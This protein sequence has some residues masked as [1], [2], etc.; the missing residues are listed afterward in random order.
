MIT[1]VRIVETEQRLL[2]R[3]R[4]SLLEG[5][6]EDE[7]LDLKEELEM[8][9][10]SKQLRHLQTTPMQARCTGNPGTKRAASDAPD[11]LPASKFYIIDGHQSQ[12]P[13][14]TSFVSRT[15]P[16]YP[17]NLSTSYESPT[18]VKAPSTSPPP[19]S[20]PSPHPHH[21]VNLHTT[22]SSKFPTDESAHIP[23]YIISPRSPVAP[24]PYHPHPPLKRWP[25]DYS[26]SEIA[27]GFQMMENLVAQSP[28]IVQ[29][30]AF[31]RVFG[32]RYVKSTVCRHRG[33]WRRADPELID[34][35][36]AMGVAEAAVWGEFVRQVEG[37]PA[38]RIKQTQGQPIGPGSVQN[39]VPLS[40]QPRTIDISMHEEPTQTEEEEEPIDEG[41]ARASET[42]SPGLELYK[43]QLVAA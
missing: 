13:R 20:S 28:S 29:R 25:N 15:S 18:P 31:E 23:S 3:V 1:T 21:T 43:L 16:P 33:V 27:L 36:I 14:S 2:Y 22:P 38:G 10:K 11:T 37:K 34:R 5:L 4:R 9:P 26:V 8:Q 32:C 41:V 24:I 17:Q 7:C 12:Q 39:K 40:T 35:F 6:S 19:S 30:T 42:P